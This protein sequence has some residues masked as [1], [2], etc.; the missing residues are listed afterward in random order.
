MV[1]DP[2]IMKINAAEKSAGWQP[3]LILIAVALFAILAAVVEG[4]FVYDYKFKL[5]LYLIYG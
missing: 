1:K 5:F 3:F 4:S 2:F